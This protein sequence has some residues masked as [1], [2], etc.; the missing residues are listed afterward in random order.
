MDE[1]RTRAVAI[2]DDDE[3]IRRS[4]ANL[5]LSLGFKAQSFASAAEFLRSPHWETTGCLVLDLRMP[6]MGGLELLA[7]LAS[8]GRRIPAVILT[9]HGDDDVRD[10]AKRAG[11]IAFI[12]KPF[13]SGAL[14][15]AVRSALCA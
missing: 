7:D 9:A 10:R 14:I 13:R 1:S 15:E 8:R 6:A 4:V 2:V 3:S 5:L 12:D 11:A